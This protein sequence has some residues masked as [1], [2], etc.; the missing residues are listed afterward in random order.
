[1]CAGA[2]AAG[3]TGEAA[4]RAEEGPTRGEDRVIVTGANAV[5]PTTAGRVRGYT[6]NRIY[7][8]KGIP[9]G[10]DTAGKNRFLPPV[11][12]EPWTG[13]RDTV[14]YNFACRQVHGNDW[15]VNMQHFVMDFDFGMMKEDCLNLN[16]WTQAVNDGKKRP[17]MFW[18]HGGGFSTGSSFELP[19]YDGEN[20]CKR[21]DVVVVSVNHRLNVLGFLNL[22]TDGGPAYAASGNVGMLDLVAALEWVRD[23][24]ERFGG[25]PGN[26]TIFGQSGGGGK[27]NTLMAMP[28][29]QGLFHKAIVQSGSMSM[30]RPRNDSARLGEEVVKVLGLAPGQLDKLQSLPYEELVEAAR[31]ANAR[32]TKSPEG[33]PG[34]GGPFWAPTADGTI[35]AGAPMIPSGPR[36]DTGIPLLV[37][38]TL[39]EVS[40]S[41]Y[42]EELEQITEADVAARVSRTYGDKTSALIQAYKKEYPK[43]RPIDILSMIESLRMGGGSLTQARNKAALGGAPVYAYRFDW[44]SSVCDGRLRAFHALDMAF[45]FD[46]TDRWESATGGGERARML[47]ARMSRAWVNF[48]RFGDPNHRDLPEWPRFDDRKPVMVF[49][50]VCELKYNPEAEIRKIALGE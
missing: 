39:N 17:V 13:I 19:C 2:G 7:T 21:G 48:A 3:L 9:Y 27:V 5:V 40:P 25:D 35:V 45:T 11:K 8:F 44:N 36:L 12:P 46:N 14:A 10:A 28:R 37:G 4:V 29:A 49:N 24:I 43:A 1:V 31:T 42:N 47:G 20:L 41:A 30:L 22:A 38:C 32:L 34:G 18:I 16:V 33:A 50:D 6:R 23:N 15:D 26:V